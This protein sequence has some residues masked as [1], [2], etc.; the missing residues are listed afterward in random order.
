M[1]NAKPVIASDMGAVRP[2]VEYGTTGYLIRDLARELPG[3]VSRMESDPAAALR[4]GQ[5]A[6]DVK[7]YS[8]ASIARR[9]KDIL[10]ETTGFPE[11]KKSA[12]IARLPTYPRDR[13]TL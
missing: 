12:S 13:A 7:C 6:Y 1:Q 5:A 4:M 9:F 2:Y 8:R 11:K 10:V 3:I